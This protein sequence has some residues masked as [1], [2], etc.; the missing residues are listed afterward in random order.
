MQ[1]V[2]LKQNVDYFDTFTLVTRIS[3]IQIL[4]ALAFIFKLIM[5]QM[6]VKLTFLNDD[7]EK[8]IYMEQ[9]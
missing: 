7:L 4:F 9:Q 3:S 1:K 6:D 8:E 2:L 5:H